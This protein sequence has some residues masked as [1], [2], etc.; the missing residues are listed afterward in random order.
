V[1]ANGAAVGSADILYTWRINGTPQS[2]Q[3]GYGKDTI[4]VEPPFYNDAFTLSV[5]ATS[6]DQSLHAAQGVSVAPQAPEFVIYELSPLAG[7]RD[8]R[9]VMGS[10]QFVTDEVAF[11]AYPLRVADPASVQAQWTLNGTP[12]QLDTGDQYLG[13]FR[14]TGG[15]SGSYTVGVSLSNAAN[16]LERAAASFLLTF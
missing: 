4:T 14:K 2:R 8:Q 15:G 10:Y 6:R 16:F 12:V 1:R 13:V 3:S 7:L 11:K 9:A 5:T